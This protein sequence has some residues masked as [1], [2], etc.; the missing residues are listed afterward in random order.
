MSTGFWEAQQVRERHLTGSRMVS[1]AL[2]L[3]VL[4]AK[5][6]PLIFLMMFK[7]ASQA[8]LANELLA[9]EDEKEAAVIMEAQR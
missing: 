6:H 9:T 1:A 2:A 8:V 7:H 3:A 5:W 4:A